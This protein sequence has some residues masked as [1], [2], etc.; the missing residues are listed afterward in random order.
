MAVYDLMTKYGNTDFLIEG[1]TDTSGPKV[2]NDKLSLDRANEVKSHLVE[3]VLILI[4][5]RQ[6]DTVKTNLKCPTV[7]EKEEFLIEE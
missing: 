4:D 3:K 1:H 5:F 7:Q 2:F 6:L